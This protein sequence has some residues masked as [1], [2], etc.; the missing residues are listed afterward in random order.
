MSYSASKNS[1]NINNTLV[2][3]TKGLAPRRLCVEPQRN[4]WCSWLMCW[5]LYTVRAVKWLSVTDCFIWQT[6][7]SGCNCRIFASYLCS[8]SHNSFTMR[9]ATPIICLS[10]VDESNWQVK[11]QRWTA[12]GKRTSGRHLYKC[13][14]P[15]TWRVY[16]SAEFLSNAS[17]EGTR[18][19]Y[20]VKC[21]HCPRKFQDARHIGLSLS[22]GHLA[23]TSDPFIGIRVAYL[24][25][26]H[27]QQG[28]EVFLF[29]KQSRPNLGLTQSPIDWLFVALPTE[30]RR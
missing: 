30:E 20:F 23:S 25:L 21:R 11:T 24:K 2:A 15:T 26:S 22:S 13:P 3:G 5:Q 1:T 16:A 27:L 28:Q 8:R 12:G 19:Y 6:F 7:V 9:L 18:L 17:V 10:S 4:D 29:T 14:V